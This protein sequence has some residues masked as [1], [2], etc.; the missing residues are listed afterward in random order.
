MPKSFV[1]AYARLLLGGRIR[2]GGDLEGRDFLLT[3]LDVLTFLEIRRACGAKLLG[4]VYDL[5]QGYLP[6]A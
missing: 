2:L 5:G 3:L 4:R 1:R 6:V